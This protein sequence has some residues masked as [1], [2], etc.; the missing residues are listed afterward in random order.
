MARLHRDE[1]FRY[2]K[3]FGISKGAL[4]YSALWETIQ[5]NVEQPDHIYLTLLSNLVSSDRGL[6]G[7]QT[8]EDVKHRNE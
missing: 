4:L 1:A 7:T 6:V 3:S 8:V 5:L 2:R